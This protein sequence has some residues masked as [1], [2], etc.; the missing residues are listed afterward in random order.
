[1]GIP[2]SCPNPVS[3]TAGGTITKYDA[4]VSDAEGVV[5]ASATDNDAG[6]VGFAQHAAASGEAIA[7]SNDGDTVKAKVT[8]T[9]VALHDYLVTNGSAGVAG[10]LITATGAAT[11]TDNIVAQAL[12]AGTTTKQEVIVIQRSF[13]DTK[14]SA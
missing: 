6:F 11:A 13:Q 10:E 8:G 7:L 3:W 9:S 14:Q 4:C 2:L 12:E 5:I 1:M